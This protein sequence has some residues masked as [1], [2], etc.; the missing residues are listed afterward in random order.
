MKRSEFYSCGGDYIVLPEKHI[1]AYMLGS[2]FEYSRTTREEKVDHLAYA[3]DHGYDIWHEIEEAKM[4]TSMLNWNLAGH[5]AYMR[6]GEYDSSNHD[7]CALAKFLALNVEIKALYNLFLSELK[8]FVWFEE[9]KD[10]VIFHHRKLIFKPLEQCTDIC[11]VIEPS[12]V[13]KMT[14][15]ELFE[16]NPWR[17]AINESD[18]NQPLYDPKAEYVC[19]ADREILINFNS[20]VSNQYKYHLGIPAEPWT[21]NPLKAKIIVLSKNPGWVDGVNDKKALDFKIQISEE[22]WSFKN[23]TLLFR[24]EGFLPYQESYVKNSLEYSQQVTHKLGDALNELGDFYWYR[25][26]NM[27]RN[28]NTQSDY[29]FFKNFAVVQYCGYTSSRHKEFYKKQILPSQEYTAKL[30]R[31]IAENRPDVKFIMPRG[32]RLWKQLLG[33]DFVEDLRQQHRLYYTHSCANQALSEKNLGKVEYT[34]ITNLL[35]KE[36]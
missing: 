3:V 11:Q 35:N 18:L 16:Q 27:L 8:S 19:P 10:E 34:Q 32:R 7:P 30:I 14:K 26:F 24:K 33:E 6:Y 2:C 1:K 31:Y 15:E 20:K 13:K 28:G 22:I 21:G 25:N 12:S 29:E 9:T 36:D 17:H 4:P 5:I 23:N